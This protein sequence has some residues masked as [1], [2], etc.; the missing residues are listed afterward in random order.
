MKK[1][2]A[3]QPIEANERFANY[4]G[5]S[6]VE[7]YEVIRKVNERCFEVRPM[8]AERDPSYK[9]EFI[10]GGFAGHCIN[11]GAQKWIITSDESA[12]IGRIRKHK[13]GTWRSKGGGRFQLAEAPHKYYDYNF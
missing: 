12:E 11:Q 7:P 4:I 9:P 2:L 5:Y 6:D 3:P 13:D 8:K 1:A 10:A